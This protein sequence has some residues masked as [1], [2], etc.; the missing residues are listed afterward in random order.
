M[1]RK[2]AAKE[3]FMLS[4]AANESR[5]QTLIGPLAKLLGSLRTVFLYLV[6]VNE[7]L[8]FYA[9]HSDNS[10]SGFNYVSKSY[11]SEEKYNQINIENN[12]IVFNLICR[13]CFVM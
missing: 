7:G 2:I 1:L 4:G 5:T 6:P 12:I 10:A 8:L 13:E 3:I 11:I 9:T